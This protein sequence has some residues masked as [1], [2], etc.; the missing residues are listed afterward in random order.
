M[1]RSSAVRLLAS[2]AALYCCVAA[3][4]AQTTVSIHDVMQSL[5]GGPYLGKSVTTSGIVVGV[6]ST[7]GFYLSEPS[8]NWDSLR[9][10]AEGMPIFLSSVSACNSVADGDSV[11]VTGTVVNSNSITPAAITAANTPGTG[12]LPTAC[13]T[14]GTAAMTQSIDLAN[15]GALTSFGDALQYTGMAA[16][17][18]S[19]VA[20]APTSG[21]NYGTTVT[22]TGQFWAVLSANIAT[23]GHMFR[24]SGIAPDEYTPTGAPTG[25]PTWSGNPQRILI[26]TT[27]FGGSRRQHHRRP[28]HYLH[29]HQHH[30]QGRHG[31]HRPHRL[32]A[33]LCAAAHL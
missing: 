2:F 13:T 21:T 23:N 19:F 15:F 22:S 4:P 31:R 26:D 20:V 10:T 27:T 11:T 28:D 16:T 3:V 17:D 33:G 18:R 29:Q 14:S 8:A 6:L 5:P 9:S 25:V 24:S 7:G 32:H 1:F 30:R 12:I